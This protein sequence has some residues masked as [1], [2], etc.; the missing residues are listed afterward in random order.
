MRALTFADAAMVRHL[1]NEHHWSIRRI[2]REMKMSEGW[3]KELLGA[4]R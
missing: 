4:D 1:R 3:V 2:A